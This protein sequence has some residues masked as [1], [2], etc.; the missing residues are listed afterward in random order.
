MRALPIL[1]QDVL[2]AVAVTALDV[3]LFS[4]PTA[5][6][7]GRGLYV[8]AAVA[9]LMWR[10]RSPVVVFGLTWLHNVLQFLV[11][12]T[13]PLLS[14]MLALFTVAS[15]TNRNTAVAALALS[16]TAGVAASVGEYARLSEPSPLALIAMPTYYFLWFAGV[17]VTGRWARLS[18]L[19]IDE[20]DYRRR[21]EAFQAVIDE[22]M[23]IARELHDVVAH[24]VTMMLLRSA[25]AQRV[26]ASDPP[27]AGRM[28][29][30]VDDF[31]QQTMSQLRD[32]LTVLRID[33]AGDDGSAA[34][35]ARPGVD[36]LKRLLEGVRQAG[37]SITHD[38][39]ADLGRIDPDVSLAAYR[40]V[41]EALTNV[42]KHVGSDAHAHV[43]LARIEDRLR[44]EVRNDVGE[45]NAAAGPA[46]PAGSSTDLSAGLSTGHGL[47]GLRERA[48]A[49]GGT[50][51]A[52]P[53]PTGGFLVRALL[54]AKG[55]PARPA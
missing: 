2:L 21:A 9:I 24:S 36:D 16:F 47:I 23:R 30:Q 19:R 38:L 12:G 54:P 18:R 27:Q 55:R 32:L 3:V 31:G 41:Q 35:T 39:A 40:I 26:L 14:L 7:A 28:L 43:E 52:G 5:P 6:S 13:T 53:T 8:A 48:A 42:T 15:R 4:T 33:E 11:P 50:L 45:G 34:G 17:W 10:R 29:A 44:V 20:L 46:S 37:L 51:D 22:R 25:N 1:L 49:V